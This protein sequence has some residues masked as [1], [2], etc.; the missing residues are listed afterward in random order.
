MG[1]GRPQRQHP[2]FA[3]RAKATVLFLAYWQLGEEN[4]PTIQLLALDRLVSWSRMGLEGSSKI[5]QVWRD[6][7]TPAR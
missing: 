2:F 5:W 3:V 7:A 6:A 1:G 4:N